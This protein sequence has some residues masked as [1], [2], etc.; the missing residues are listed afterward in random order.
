MLQRAQWSWVSRQ[1]K[2]KTHAA[3]VST[4]C[5]EG[6]E[7]WTGTVSGHLLR[8]SNLCGVSPWEKMQAVGVPPSG[9]PLT[10]GRRI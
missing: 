3:R 7:R 8:H 9:D 1:G 4:S 5:L 10:S 2:K 6:V